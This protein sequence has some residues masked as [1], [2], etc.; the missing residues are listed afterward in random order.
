M[1]AS[2][3]HSATIVGLKPWF[4]WPLSR[5]E[6]W[7]APVAAERLAALRIGLAFVLL[8][9]VLLTYLPMGSIFFGKDSFGSP[10]IFRNHFTF[11][12]WEWSLLLNVESP[13]IIQASLIIWAFTVFLLLIGFWTRLAAIAVWLL[14]SSFANINGSIDNAGDLVRGI[15]LFY[16]MLCPCGAAWSVD[17]WIKRRKGYLTGQVLVY[18]WPIRLLFLQMIFIYFMNG[19]YKASGEA[20]LRGDSLYY[21]L[22]DLTLA[23]W[24]YAQW[25][26]PPALLRLA[27]WIVMS[28]EVSFPLLVL[29]RPT[30]LLALW[31]GVAFHLGIGL[32]MELGGFPFYM[33]CLYLPLVP[34]ENWT[35]KNPVC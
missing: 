23:R 3:S 14:S 30:R 6:W 17:A 32:S 9:D 22:C 35:R 15:V 34:W 33:L 5:W 24:S 4:P 29:W 18:P 8:L 28:W 11:P 7:T 27:S 25:P 26:I 12:S 13:W 16:L 2:L 20:W 31:L 10:A 21:V 1:S 19:I